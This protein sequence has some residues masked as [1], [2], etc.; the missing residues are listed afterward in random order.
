NV[1]INNSNSNSNVKLNNSTNN[2]SE[3]LSYTNSKLNSKFNEISV[4][5]LV[6]ICGIFTG[7]IILGN[8]YLR[9]RRMMNQ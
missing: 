2:P 9:K 8:T 3:N 4:I 5:E 1:V 7:L 6:F